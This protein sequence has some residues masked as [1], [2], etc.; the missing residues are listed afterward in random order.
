MSLSPRELGVAQALLQ[1][2]NE[3]VLP[4]AFELQARLDRGEVLG[5]RDRALLAELVAEQRRIPA[6]V[7]KQPR[8]ESLARDVE[9]LLEYIAWRARRNEAACAREVSA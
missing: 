9:A 5:H 7:A 4:R 1:R 6:L 3:V 8:F 2:L